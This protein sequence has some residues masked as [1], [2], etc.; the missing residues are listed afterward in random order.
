MCV[1]CW[2]DIR[3]NHIGFT[4]SAIWKIPRSLLLVIHLVSTISVSVATLLPVNSDY[5]HFM[6]TCRPTWLGCWEQGPRCCCC[7]WRHFWPRQQTDRQWASSPDI[8]VQY[9][10]SMPSPLYWC[11]LWTCWIWSPK[12]F[13]K[14]GR[15]MHQP[16]LKV[17]IPE[18]GYMIDHYKLEHCHMIKI[19]ISTL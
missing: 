19:M 13:Y 11:C 14:I 7:C 1:R 9:G 5:P 16:P 6:L 12:N 2:D 8:A 15:V 3:P 17:P 10:D 18:T 4:Y